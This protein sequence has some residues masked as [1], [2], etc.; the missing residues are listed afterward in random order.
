MLLYRGNDNSENNSY[1]SILGGA[2]Q[3]DPL[4]GDRKD[5]ARWPHGILLEE[6]IK[7]FGNWLTF[8]YGKSFC[9][10]KLKGRMVR[11]TKHITWSFDQGNMITRPIVSRLPDVREG[12]L[13]V[14]AI[15][16]IINYWTRSSKISWFVGGE[17]INY[18]PMPKAEANN[19]SASHR[20]ITIFCENRVQ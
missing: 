16:L 18:L 13:I 10:S 7:W 19:W 12:H 1:S 14:S 8:L 17:Q 3:K 20:Q 9:F 11:S 4:C 2:G 5:N 15:S 6:R